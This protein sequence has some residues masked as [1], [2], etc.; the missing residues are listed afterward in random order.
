MKNETVSRGLT[1]L[2]GA[3]AGL[4]LGY[5]LQSEKGKAFREQLGENLGDALDDLVEYGQEQIDELLKTLN[6]SLD[7][8][9]NFAEM[10]DAQ[11]RENLGDVVEEA[12]DTLEDAESSF[13]NGMDKA[14]NKLLKKF[15]DAGTI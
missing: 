8:G 3:A 11:F 1:F 2:A 9:F 7:K 14:K 5:Y 4:A 10:I 12:G 6:L 15:A 13:E